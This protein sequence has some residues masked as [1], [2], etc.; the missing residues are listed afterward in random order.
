MSPTARA[1]GSTASRLWH[2]CASAVEEFSYARC[3]RGREV[4]VR[5]LAGLLENVG[6]RQRHAWFPLRGLV[7]ALMRRTPVWTAMPRTGSTEA[8]PVPAP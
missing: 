3:T 4:G 1:P 2:T 6:Y 5:L 7:A 8:E